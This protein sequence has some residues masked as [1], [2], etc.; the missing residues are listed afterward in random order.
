[1]A[2]A[3]TSCCNERGFS[4]APIAVKKF[5]CEVMVSK[6]YCIDVAQWFTLTGP[7]WKGLTEKAGQASMGYLLFDINKSWKVNY[8]P[9]LREKAFTLKYFETRTEYLNL[10]L[11]PYR[12]LSKF[13]RT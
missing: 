2:N 11:F 12:N 3:F 10:L 6:A 13:F 5:I 7:S 8:M 1:M 4:K 9:Y